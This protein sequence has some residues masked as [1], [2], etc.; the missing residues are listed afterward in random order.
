[1][2][3]N[4][5]SNAAP[6]LRALI[7]RS[8]RRLQHRPVIVAVSGGAD[9]VAL[10]HLMRE[11]LGDRAAG[12]LIVA[13]LHHGLR[14][15]A[16]DEDE[17]FVVALARGAGCRVE[18]A[19]ADVAARAAR[20]RLSLEEA[21]RL[22]RREFLT[23][24]SK[25]HGHAPVALAHTRDDQAETL[26]HNLLRGAGP[27]GLAAM[28]L[29]GPAPFFRP[30]LRARRAELRDYLRKRGHAWREDETNA[31][32]RFTRN[33]IR[34][35]VL[36]LLE[37]ALNP[38][39][40]DVL[41]RAAGIQREVA[42]WLSR[43]AAEVLEE[44]GIGAGA[45][46]PVSLERAK[47]IALPAPVRHE[48]L[49][50]IGRRFGGPARSWSRRAIRSVMGR[51]FLK[52]ATGAGRAAVELPGGWRVELRGDRLTIDRA[53]PRPQGRPVGGHL[54]TPSE[55]ELPLTPG[56]EVPWG[57]GTIRVTCLDLTAPLPPAA[58]RPPSPW[59][60][61]LDRDELQDRLCIRA[62]RPGDRIRPIGLEGHRRL[63]D[64]LVDARVPAAARGRAALVAAP[65]PGGELL[66]VPGVIRSGR[67]LVTDHTRRVVLLE[68]FGPRP[69]SVQRP[70]AAVE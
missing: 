28:P 41:L 10:F 36:P 5:S 19:R 59:S 46:P 53:V 2:A 21:G 1:M 50:E 42:E 62:R 24:L 49:R 43:Q 14:G 3:T 65:D 70:P 16:A 32:P 18:V 44:A 15:A 25:E 23:K 66:W 63:Q 12:E 34:N 35:D 69:W 40:V 9:S 39:A 27:R 54:T 68:W 56:A 67:A 37:S 58:R 30:L 45:A 6:R 64:V 33:R 31:D 8:L 47:V 52:R 17:A 26:L 57:D 29:V 55:F 38:R 22:A 61:L 51:E 48:V 4:A 7:E 60:A 13:H 20:D 11:A